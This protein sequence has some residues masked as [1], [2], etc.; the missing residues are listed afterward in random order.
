M[1]G[2]RRGSKER[3][4]GTLLVAMETKLV[5][6]LPFQTLKKS[7]TTRF[8]GM[9]LVVDAPSVASNQAESCVPAISER[10]GS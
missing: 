7:H 6:G 10:N 3:G 8:Y 4:V 5:L 1:Q 2:R 9:N